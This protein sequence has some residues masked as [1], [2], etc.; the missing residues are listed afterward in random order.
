MAINK[1]NKFGNI[2]SIA[3]PSGLIFST[4]WVYTKFDPGI[5]QIIISNDGRGKKVLKREK[6]QCS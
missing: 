6:S 1:S 2:I 5:L 3:L 4:V